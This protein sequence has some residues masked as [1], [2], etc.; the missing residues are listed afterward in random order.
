M[1]RGG[2]SWR[3]AEEE[4]HAGAQPTGLSRLAADPG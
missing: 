4:A 3:R 2:V 1:R